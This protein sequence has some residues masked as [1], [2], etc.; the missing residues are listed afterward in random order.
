[1]DIT[2]LLCRHIY[3]LVKGE[4]L[5]VDEDDLSA[6]YE[7]ALVSERTYLEK[8]WEKCRL[9]CPVNFIDENC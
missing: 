5:V 1:L 9:T 2:Q 7:N 3:Y 8:M 6:G 4:K